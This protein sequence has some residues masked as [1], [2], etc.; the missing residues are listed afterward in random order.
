MGIGHE[1]FVQYLCDSRLHLQNSKILSPGTHSSQ[2][3]SVTD[4]IRG[5]KAFS[6]LVEWCEWC[7]K[8]FVVAPECDERAMAWFL[9]CNP[10]FWLTRI[11]IQAFPNGHHTINIPSEY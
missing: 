11:G 6:L 2:L 1:A 5:P 7:L 8:A 9:G 3:H 10:G 4:I